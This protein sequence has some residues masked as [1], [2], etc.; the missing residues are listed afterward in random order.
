MISQPK[1]K[2]GQPV[3]IKDDVDHYIADHNKK[4]DTLGNPRPRSIT[5]IGILIEECYSGI[6]ISYRFVQLTILV[7]E[8]ALVSEIPN[9]NLEKDNV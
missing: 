9:L 3:Y 8:T 7:P 2:I 6:Q 1:F 4:Y 5:V